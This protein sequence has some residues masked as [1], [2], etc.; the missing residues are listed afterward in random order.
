MKAGLCGTQVGTKVFLEM[1]CEEHSIGGG[2]E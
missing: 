2:G 1:V